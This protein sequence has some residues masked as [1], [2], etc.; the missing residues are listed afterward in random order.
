M[1]SR[2]VARQ[3]LRNDSPLPTLKFRQADAHHFNPITRKQKS[4]L[5]RDNYFHLLLDYNLIQNELIHII[6]PEKRRRK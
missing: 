6:N 1:R 2:I 3:L 5:P 4:L